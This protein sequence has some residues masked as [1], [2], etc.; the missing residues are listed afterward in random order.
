MSSSPNKKKKLS[1]LKKVKT[2][3]GSGKSA[4]RNSS[5]S[6]SAKDD[7]VYWADDRE[8]KTRRSMFS[9]CNFQYLLKD[10]LLEVSYSGTVMN[11]EMTQIMDRIYALLRTNFIDKVL[12]DSRKSDVILEFRDSLDF[13]TSHPPEFLKVK[14]AVVETKKREAQYRL[15]EMFAKN[16]DLNLRFFTSIEDAESWLNSDK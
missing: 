7:F 4:K 3:S 6:I 16:R 11:K 10:D 9:K 13:V 14:T 15:Y 1:A 5:S 12:I 8:V 2:K